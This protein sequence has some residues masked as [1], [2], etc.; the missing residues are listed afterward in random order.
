MEMLLKAA[1]FFI[2]HVGPIIGSIAA[3][4]GFVFAMPTLIKSI[5][6][7]FGGKEDPKFMGKSMTE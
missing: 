4:K 6:D 3:A 5:N 7:A 1:P 2:P